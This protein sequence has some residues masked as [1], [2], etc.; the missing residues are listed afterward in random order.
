MPQIYLINFTCPKPPIAVFCNPRINF[1]SDKFGYN[2]EPINPR[3]RPSQFF[4]Y[5]K[6]GIG[7]GEELSVIIKN[8]G[9]EGHELRMILKNLGSLL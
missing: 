6:N 2:F 1:V 9:F 3:K 5:E 4:E 8:N 7:L